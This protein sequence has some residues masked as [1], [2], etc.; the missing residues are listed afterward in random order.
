M[1]AATIYDV[2]REAGVSIK[3]VSRILNHDA[4]VKPVN[5]ERVLQAVAALDYRPNLSAR[6]LAGSRSFVVAAFV[7][8]DLT[9]D[10]WRSGRAAD[11]LS[12][13]QLGA[14][15]ECRQA[16]YHFVVELID[17]DPS[18]LE[19]EV[20]DVLAALKPDGVLLTPPS[21][22]DPLMLALLESASTPVVRLGSSSPLAGGVQL[23]L[24]D[25]GGAAAAAGHLI[26][27]G[28]RRIGCIVGDV[29]YGSSQ[30]RLEGFRDALQEAGLEVD[31][32]LVKRGDFTFQSGLEGALEL[33]RAPRP[34][35]A[36]FAQ[37]DEMAL[38]CLTALDERGV[39]TPG[40]VSVVGFD[41]SAGAR[42][43]LPRLTSVRQPLAERAAEGVRIL[44]GKSHEPE[45][46]L[47]SE[48]VVRGSTAPPP[49]A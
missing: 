11:Y 25:R 36:I 34:P 23:D 8:A 43:S 32:T 40:Q 17:H 13:V 19:R 48:I 5:R 9:V 20:R 1:K 46:A 6:S 2:A 37:S 39:A 33:L 12:R 47:R 44:I 3:T 38:G 49:P 35:T 4:S 42:F 45:P 26:E 7:D 18:S 10:H 27:L 16:G 29:R 15:L 14:T 24:D 31:E 21:C 30:A 41:D 28:H 22:D